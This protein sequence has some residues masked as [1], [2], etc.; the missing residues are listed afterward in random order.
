MATSVSGL[1]TIDVNTIVSQLMT[2]ER[3]PLAAMQRT[4]G[5]IQTKLSAFGRLQ[6]QLAAFQTAAQALTRLDR[7]SATTAA[8]SDE[9]AAR[10]STAG[11][12][13]PGSYTLVVDALAQRQSVASTTWSGA[14]A[15]VG[16]GTLR[17]QFGRLDAGSFSPDG[18][19]PE[20]QITIPPGATLAQVRDAVNAANAGVRASLVADGGGMRLL[21]RGDATGADNAFSLQADGDPGLSTLA[22]T[23]GAAGTGMTVTQAATDARFSVDGLE[24]T[25][26]GN[27]LEGVVEGLG[28]ELRR[29][30]PEPVLIDVTSD[31]AAMRSAVEGFV[32]AWNDLNKLAAE[33]TRYDDATRTAGTLQGNS[34]AVSTQRRLREIL[35]GTVDG[36]PLQRLSDAGI[37]LQRDGSLAIDGSRLDAALAEPSRLQA[38][39]AADSAVAGQRGIARR[40]DTLARELL[41][42]DGPLGGATQTLQGQRDRITRQQEAFEVRLSLI[43]SRLRRQYTALDASLAQWSSTS[44]FIASRFADKA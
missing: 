36:A 37:T 35:T 5:G 29:A 15:I 30:G 20:V 39:F 23:P 18:A 31:R 22:F 25:S 40:F 7:W 11:T 21:L 38:L 17:L 2:V 26:A 10:A 3:Q 42:T 44:A 12:A 28:I 33:L 13:Q 14:D 6:G 41:G 16:G 24:L 8:S 43:E 34:T 19:R 27:R 4:L 1:T 9:T 32:T